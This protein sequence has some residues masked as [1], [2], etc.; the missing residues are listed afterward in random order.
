MTD[1]EQ[2]QSAEE[3]ASEL[4][5][6]FCDNFL[7]AHGFL[8]YG[9]HGQIKALIFP[10]IAW[11]ESQASGENRT[12]SDIVYPAVVRENESL[13]IRITALQSRYEEEQRLHHISIVALATEAEAHKWQAAENT[14]LRTELHNAQYDRSKVSIHGTDGCY[15]CETGRITLFAE[16]RYCPKCKEALLPN[17]GT[18]KKGEE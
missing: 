16:S 12:A 2:D 10:G 4:A 9:F 11:K 13:R 18:A 14:R 1:K 3:A 7:K 6:T 8:P 5:H 17:Q 15:N